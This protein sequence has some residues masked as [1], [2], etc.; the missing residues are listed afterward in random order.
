MVRRDGHDLTNRAPKR[1][2][3]MSTTRASQARTGPSVGCTPCSTCPPLPPPPPPPPCTSTAFAATSFAERGTPS[4]WLARS[5]DV[6]SMTAPK[7]TSCARAPTP[8]RGSTPVAVGRSGDLRGGEGWPR[9]AGG[10]GGRARL[11][12]AAV[13][14]RTP[15]GELP[16]HRRR[17]FGL[18]QQVT[19]AVPRSVWACAADGP[20]PAQSHFELCGRLLR[21]GSSGPWAGGGAA[22]GGGAHVS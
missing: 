10:E 3:S 4:C 5:S 20:P 8:Q 6:A 15:T 13:H 12:G 18:R 22:T 7:W 1:R 19:L 14:T 2:A 21:L 11:H 16:T 17:V 9:A